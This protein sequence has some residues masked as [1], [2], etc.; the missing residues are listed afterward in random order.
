[1][2]LSELSPTS[3]ELDARLGNAAER[4]AA[5]VAAADERSR[6]FYHKIFGEPLGAQAA[7]ERTSTKSRAMVTPP[8][9][10]F[11]KFLMVAAWPPER[12]RIDAAAFVCGLGIS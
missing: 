12:L 7:V 11:R 1:M 6:P 3:A 9:C 2:V 10:V 8:W 4:F 5:L